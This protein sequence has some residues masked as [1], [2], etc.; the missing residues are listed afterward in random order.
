MTPA[1]NRPIAIMTTPPARA[2]P[3]RC[4]SSAEPTAEAPAPSAVN[5]TAKPATNNNDA[6]HARERAAVSEASV[7]GVSS[8]PAALM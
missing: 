8:D 2:S 1:I 6:T 5:T 7:V 4:A 3:C